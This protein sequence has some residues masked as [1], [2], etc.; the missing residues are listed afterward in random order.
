MTFRCTFRDDQGAARLNVDAGDQIDMRDSMRRGNFLLID[1]E[2]VEVVIDDG[3]VEET[4]ADNINI[5][6]GE[7]ASDIYFVPRTVRGGQVVTFMQYLDY[8]QG[9]IISAQDGRATA[10]FWTDGGRWLWHKKPPLNWCTQWVAKIEPR[11]ILLTPQL[12]G[13]LQNVRY[14]PL[15]HTR[16]PFPNDP[17]F[18]DG[19]E[20][21]RAGPSLF[22]DWN[23][24]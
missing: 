18:L 5:L 3:I 6:A 20:T 14:A 23:L 19:G 7:F 22:S 13:R 11:V 15:Q 17:Y 2:Q 24:P 8:Q 21:Q 4:D 10:D 12:A 16:S 1:G 9:A